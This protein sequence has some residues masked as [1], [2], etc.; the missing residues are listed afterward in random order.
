MM[1]IIL[2][3]SLVCIRLGVGIED[4]G[5]INQLQKTV[6]SARRGQNGISRDRGD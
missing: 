6:S 5:E 4:E 1:L 2:I 3:S